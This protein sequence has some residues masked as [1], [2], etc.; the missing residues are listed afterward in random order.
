MHTLH[1]I[2][3][4]NYAYGKLRIRYLPLHVKLLKSQSSFQKKFAMYSDDLIA[5]TSAI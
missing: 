4:D 1:D 2:R 5:L 3:V